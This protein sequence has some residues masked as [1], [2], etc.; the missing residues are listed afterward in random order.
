MQN[1]NYPTTQ[2]KLNYRIKIFD[3]AILLLITIK[4][5]YKFL[6]VKDYPGV[7]V[8]FLRS[9]G[10]SDRW[11]TDHGYIGI[12]A[13]AEAYLFSKTKGQIANYSINI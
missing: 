5:E 9:V 12:P 4:I 6:R 8:K 11:H 13:T 7:E 1:K 10:T 2:I 3:T